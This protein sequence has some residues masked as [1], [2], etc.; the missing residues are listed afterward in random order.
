MINSDFYFFICPHCKDD[1]IVNKR[2]LNCKIFRHGVFKSNYTQV[3]PHATFEECK[4][5][6]E[7]DQI[8]GC[9]KPFEVIEKNGKLTAIICDYK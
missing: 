8:L 1:I 6:I 4:R 5:L 7:T 3:N 2:E 9:G